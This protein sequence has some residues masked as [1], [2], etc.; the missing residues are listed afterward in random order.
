MPEEVTWYR[1]RLDGGWRAVAVLIAVGHFAIPFFLLLLRRVK[2]SPVA[3]ATVSAWLLL[4][5]AVD[6]YWLVFPALHPQDASF[7]WTSITAL[8][9]VGGVTVA[10]WLWL[11]HGGFTVPVRDPFLPHSLRVPGA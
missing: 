11:V 8:A 10:A 7:H 4:M 9:G 3:L 1:A 6:V 2:Q 5:H